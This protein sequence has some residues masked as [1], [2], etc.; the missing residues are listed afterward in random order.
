[1]PTTLTIAR[2]WNGT[3]ATDRERTAVDLRWVPGGLGIDVGAPFHGDSAPPARPGPCD[4]LW[5]Y[6]VVEV[7]LAGSAADSAVEGSLVPYT[8]IELS[9]HG[10]YLVLRLLGVRNPIDLAL[11]LAYGAEVAGERWR[12]RAVVPSAY[13]PDGELTGNAYAIHGVGPR[14]RFLAAHP[15]PGE[16]PD[17]HQPERF[18]ALDLGPREAGAER[19]GC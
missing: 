13:L 8:E 14:R 16:R 7:F 9:P 10:H 5:S 4:R 1:M 18:V 12:G 3:A 6:E 2:L 17:F 19:R 11:P 15:V